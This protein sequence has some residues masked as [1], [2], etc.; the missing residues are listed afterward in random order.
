MASYLGATPQLSG[1]TSLSAVTELRELEKELARLEAYYKDNKICTFK[2][3]GN[4]NQFFK[5]RK[6]TRLLFGSNRS[7]KSAMSTVE[8]IAC[9]LGYRPWL[10]YDHPDRI[11]RLANGEP[12][13]TPCI[14]HHLL[15]N[16]KVSGVQVFIP[17]MEEWLPKGSAKIRKNNLGHPVSV[18]FNNGSI[19]H[20]LS[21][22]Q[23]TSSLEGAAGHVVVS[24]EPPVRDKWIALQRGLV[25]YSG[26]SWIAA[27]PI[28]A[29]HF[30]AEL[31]ARAADPNS[32]VE[33]IS[34]SIEDNRKSRGGYLDDAAVD[35]FIASLD[36]DEIEPRLYGRPAH[37]AGA[38]FKKW[39]PAPPFFVDPFPIPEDWPRIMAVDP[40]GRKPLGAVW[41]AISPHNK[42]YVYRELYSP[43]LTTVKEVADWIK[44][45]EGWQR[46]RNGEFVAGLEAEPIALR[47]IDTS[48]NTHEMTSG[49][50]VTGLFAQNGLPM[51]PAQKLG[52]LASIDKIN[53]MLNTD[54]EFEWK[55]GPDL[56]VFNN[57]IRVAYE[58]QNFVWKPESAQH[59]ATGADPDDKPLKT[60]DDLVDCIRYLVMTN[61]RYA[62]LVRMLNMWGDR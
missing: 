22:E 61:A 11:V 41:I 28:K 24:D 53:T 8:E 3:L 9:C 60:N 26:I 55:S 1:G 56:I 15:E 19:I 62:S 31:M 35:R 21:Q 49:N 20:V 17:K 33:L 10:P 29:S 18:E 51:M 57:C 4:Q 14:V 32:D 6:Q 59:K 47:L 52:Y 46:L 38:V 36:P 54:S 7:G 34:I 27:T 30:M 48:G 23:S 12:I 16:L 45:V 44:E 39:R 42:W 43:A 25:D 37:L 5:S 2:P 50:T 58:F 40:A 13:P